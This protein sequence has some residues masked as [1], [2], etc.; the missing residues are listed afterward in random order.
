MNYELSYPLNTVFWDGRVINKMPDKVILK[1]LENLKS[2]GIGK[3][4]LAGYHLEEDAGFDMDHESARIGK[5]LTANGFTVAQ[6][7]GVATTFTAPGA[8]QENGSGEAEADY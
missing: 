5:I 4:M 3:V 6:H 2:A 8:S 1:R 7:H